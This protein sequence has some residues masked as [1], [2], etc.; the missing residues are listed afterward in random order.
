MQA[1]Q[2]RNAAGTGASRAH[3]S[4]LRGAW[5]GAWCVVRCV[6]VRWVW[7]VMLCV[8]LSG[9]RGKGEGRRAKLG[10]ETIDAHHRAP[11]F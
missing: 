4:L 2:L 11:N 1:A 6:C 7:C 8:R 9:A 3:P 5:R 10:R